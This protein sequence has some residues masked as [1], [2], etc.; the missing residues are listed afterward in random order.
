MRSTI[1]REYDIRGK[2]GHDLLI[3][4]V[5]HITSAIASFFI[6]RVPHFK[7]VAVGMDGRSHSVTIKEE[8]CRALIDNGI[9]VVFLG[10]CPSPALYFSL[11]NIAVDGGLMITASHN[12]KE[13]NGIKICLGKNVI[14]GKQIAEIQ[15]LFER[16]VRVTGREPGRLKDLSIIPLYTQWLESHFSSLIGM[17][18]PVIIDC[19]HAAAAVVIPDL[20]KRMKWPEVRLLC[21]TLDGSFPHHDPDPTVKENVRDISE[22]LAT[23]DAILGFG[24]DGD[25]DRM[26]VVTKMGTLIPGDRL[27]AVFAQPIIKERPATTVVADIKS[28]S[29]LIEFLEGL[30]AKVHISP[31]GHAIIKDTMKKHDAIL[32]GELSCHFFFAD[33]YF[34]YDD[35]IYAMLRLIEILV[36]TG[37]SIEELIERFP[38]RV[39]TKEFRI[40]YNESQKHEIINALIHAFEQIPGTQ[41]ITVD[42]VRASVAYGWGLVRA[43]NTQPVLSMRFE[44]DTLQ[45]L[46]RI[47]S[48]F[49]KVLASYFEPEVLE[50]E[51]ADG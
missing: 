51:L 3:E 49:I 47:K 46:A 29:G 23:T 43:S 18:L 15:S 27:L 9:D 26:A 12:P 16:R 32:A 41:L 14:W 30:G 34:G 45:G 6:S 21:A 8:V 44:S 50:R 10:I 11:F 7:T 39:S 35:G 2:V 5:Y 33:R 20:V 36:D 38:A 19:G 13:Y 25:A 22:A 24:L 31:T 1:F 40:E 42:G 17:R 37:K 28:S 48:D 4:D